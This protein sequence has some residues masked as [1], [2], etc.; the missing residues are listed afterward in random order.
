MFISKEDTIIEHSVSEQLSQS[1][2]KTEERF[3]TYKTVLEKQALFL[4]AVLE[5]VK[6]SKE[7]MTYKCGL[8]MEMGHLIQ[9]LSGVINEQSEF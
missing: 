8:V 4:S 5:C 9:N 1:Q 6:I 7:A 3:S 2:V